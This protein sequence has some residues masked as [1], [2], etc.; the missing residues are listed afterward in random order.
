[1][2]DWGGVAGGSSLAGMLSRGVSR[3]PGEHGIWNGAREVTEA[4]GKRKR[5]ERGVLHFA[6]LLDLLYKL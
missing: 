6:R 4:R 3:R 5:R 2:S 1:M